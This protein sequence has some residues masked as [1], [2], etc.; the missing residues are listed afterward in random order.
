MQ[1]T[2]QPTTVT[3]TPTAVV[4]QLVRN[5]VQPPAAPTITPRPVD[6]GGQGSKGT[7]SGSATQR[8][9]TTSPTQSSRPAPRGSNLDVL[10]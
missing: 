7:A 1:I 8:Q 5:F 10:V 9:E 2:P 6:A 3:P 4:P